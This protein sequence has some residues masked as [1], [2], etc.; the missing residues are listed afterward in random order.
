M[1]FSVVFDL[2]L[3]MHLI[4]YLATVIRVTSFTVTSTVIN[5]AIPLPYAAKILNLAFDLIHSDLSHSHIHFQFLIHTQMIL[6][7]TQLIHV[8]SI[9]GFIF[10]KTEDVTLVASVQGAACCWGIIS[11]WIYE[12]F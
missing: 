7:L 2:V 8:Y 4:S 12:L 3:N 10:V 6:L 11:N 9:G 5:F 1:M